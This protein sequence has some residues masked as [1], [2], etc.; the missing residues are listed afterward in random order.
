MNSQDLPSFIHSLAEIDF[1]R[2]TVGLGKDN[3]IVLKNRPL[4]GYSRKNDQEF[5]NTLSNLTKIIKETGCLENPEILKDLLTISTNLIKRVEE[6]NNPL[7]LEEAYT[8]VADL[9]NQIA[10]GIWQTSNLTFTETV[11]NMGDWKGVIE[12]ES[13]IL[14]PQNK[15]QL[16]LMNR[17]LYISRT[18]LQDDQK[19]E[20]TKILKEI[21][22]NHKNISSIQIQGFKETLPVKKADISNLTVYYKG[23]QKTKDVIPTGIAFASGAFGSVHVHKK[24]EHT[25]VK[26]SKYSLQNE[27]VIG[28]RLSHPRIV[29][30]HRLY[31][32]YNP[33]KD[34]GR[35][36]KYKMTM[37]R[38]RGQTLEEMGQDSDCF[39]ED[40]IKQLLSQGQE[41][42]QYL[43]EQN[44]VWDDL[45]P[46]NIFA[47]K[48][49]L[50]LCDFGE[51]FE[52]YDSIEKTKGLLLG[53]MQIVTSIMTYSDLYVEAKEAIYKDY[54]E[55]R[56]LELKNVQQNKARNQELDLIKRELID[57]VVYP[58]EIFTKQDVIFP[59]IENSTGYDKVEPLKTLFQQ[60]PEMNDQEKVQLLN[61]FF[62]SAIRSVERIYSKKQEEREKL[63]KEKTS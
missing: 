24:N 54:Q 30:S 4:F 13:K 2:K 28:N 21:F 53:S 42:C 27:F 14:D 17:T 8:Q 26:K 15:G 48:D 33:S 7:K 5:I 44:V 58:I 6:V 35:Q 37:E 11:E 25:A 51:W 36:Q 16:F 57:S 49:G 41:C 22:S 61:R 23:M 29:K 56:R 10:I 20:L 55:F 43:F 32:K 59:Q 31:I 47:T 19:E 50:K 46:R 9:A 45:H 60:L 38:V 52:E 63:G 18:L 1:S 39:A 62:E 40:K 12:A 34:P 3:S